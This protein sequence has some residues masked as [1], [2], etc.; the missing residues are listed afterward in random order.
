MP[1]APP[2]SSGAELARELLRDAFGRVAESVPHVVAGLDGEDLS[3]RPDPGANSIGWLVWHLSRVQ[4]DHLA[5]L[6]GV[7][8]AWVADGWVERF[9]LPYAAPATG[10]GMSTAEV[11][12]FAVSDPAV[13]SGYHDAVHRLTLRVLRDLDTEGLTRVVDRRWDPPVTALVRLVSVVNDT[14][15]HVGQAAY[16]RGLLE[17]RAP[18][19]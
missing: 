16:V 5:D 12:A 7:D 14:T 4:D 13:L 3:W 1:T 15:Q 11:D 18:G 19:S 9:G 2:P 10:Y 8:Q 6:A 17:R